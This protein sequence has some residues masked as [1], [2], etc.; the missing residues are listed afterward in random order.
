MF[1]FR[2]ASVLLFLFPIIALTTENADGH[3]E[4]IDLIVEVATNRLAVSRH[5]DHGVFEFLAGT[6]LTDE[7]GAGVT[8]PSNGLASGTE[9]GYVV[10]QDLLYWDGTNLAQPSATL[11]ILP[12]EGA[13]YTVTE[14]TGLQT[15]IHWGTYDGSLFWDEH[16]D[17]FL[18]PSSAPQGVYGLAVQFVAEAYG[19][20]EPVLVPFVYGSWSETE[21]DDAIELMEL[22]V[23]PIS[24]PDFDNDGQ[25]DVVDLALWSDD[26]GVSSQAGHGQGDADGDGDVDGL[27]FLAWQQRAGTTVSS[28]ESVPEPAS[29]Q[30]ALALS[31]AIGTHKRFRGRE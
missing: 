18:T 6:I 1:Q 3:G 11:S 26:Y 25:F 8:D 4:P 5:V 10:T 14:T 2:Y 29:L 27:D 7:P 19:P 21:I 20:S 23:Q 9:I 31:L 24:N 28:V 16:A 13:G 12:H 15:G 22:E 17:F 30:L